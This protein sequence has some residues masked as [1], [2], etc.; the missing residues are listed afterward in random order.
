MRG[1]FVLLICCL[2]AQLSY[3]QGTVSDPLQESEMT[4]EEQIEQMLD[5]PKGELETLKSYTD[6]F[7]NNC[8][9]TKHPIVGGGDLAFLCRCASAKFAKEMSVENIKEIQKGTLEGDFQKLRLLNFVYAPCLEGPIFLMIKKSC[10]N[11]QK[12]RYLMNNPEFTCGC[13][14]K[15]VTNETITKA[16]PKYIEGF[17]KGV[18]QDV[19]PLELLV[20]TQTFERNYRHF[21]K[22]CVKKFEKR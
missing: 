18:Y 17:A 9:E 12:N 4:S 7:Y 21:S 20:N 6:A 5:G 15:G 22:Y 13:V 10:L 19:P 3:A 11:N 1:L 14:A 16:S 2:F 8:A